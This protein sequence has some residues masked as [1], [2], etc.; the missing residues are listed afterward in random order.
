MRKIFT[1]DQIRK[2][3]QYTIDHEPISSLNLMERAASKA[4]DV[5]VEHY[6]E[7][8]QCFSI[9]CGI[10]NNGGDGLV[11][12][13][14][15]HELG[16]A[17]EVF[18][19]QFSSK[20]SDDHAVNLDR[21]PIEPTY[22]TE[23]DHQFR[24]EKQAVIVDAIFGSGLSRAVE[25]FAAEVIEEMNVQANGLI[26]IDVPSG[27]FAD[28]S[29]AKGAIARSTLC[30]SFQ[31]PKLA[32]LM[33][34][35]EAYVPHWQVI[36]IGLHP[37]Y[38]KETKTRYF[39]F[40]KED[41]QSILKDRNL[42][43]HKGD[44]GRAFMIAGSKGKMGAA[45]LASRACMRSGVGLLTV[46]SPACGYEILQSSIPEAMVEVGEQ[47]DYLS[48]IKRDIKFDAIGVGPGIGLT[49]ATQNFIKQL[50]QL[51]DSPMLI[52]AD[53]LNIL[54]ENKT[55]L[56]FLPKGCILTPH[57]GE[58]KRLAGEWSDDFERLEML[59]E[60]A[61]KYGQYVVLK[62]RFTSIA[63][64]DGRVY[65]NSTGNPGMATAGSGDVL[66]G[67]LTSL[68]AQ[69]YASEQVAL[70]GVYLHGLAGDIAA[71]LHGPRSMIAGDIVDCI[72]EAYMEFERT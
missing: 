49:D 5:I 37:E 41:A 23:S 21:L 39:Y 15:L 60:F 29:S 20:Y 33:P 68:M 58:F 45:V 25:G 11:I 10:G 17:V 1:T 40:K 48:D 69:G 19:V 64:P 32:F 27:L 62:G 24:V 28:Q 42:F 31:F 54:A 13:R 16:Y 50:I 59:Q 18:I 9:F 46:Q 67:I 66:S 38:I 43:S 35:N 70:L 63:C 34:E 8:T 55:W 6:P 3:D 65:F 22:L 12:A 2:A 30:L 4:T 26:A 51:N 36:D 44:N 7:R 56:S 53:A 72:A 52:D 57:P 61:R 47:E 71:D 14:L